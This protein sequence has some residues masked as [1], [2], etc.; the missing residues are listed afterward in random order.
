MLSDACEESGISLRATKMSDGEDETRVHARVRARGRGIARAQRSAADAHRSRARD[1]IVDAEAVT[2]DLE[3]AASWPRPGA[4]PSL[5]PAT[6][7]APPFDQAAEIAKLV[8]STAPVWIAT[9]Q[10]SDRYLRGD[11]EVRFRFVELHRRT[12]LVRLMCPVLQVSPS[13][14][15]GWRS[16]P[17]VSAW[18]RTVSFWRMFGAS[19][20]AIMTAAARVACMPLCARRVDGPAT[21]VRSV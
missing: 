12:W 20:P 6:P 7:V 2:G 18:L 3:R 5:T 14:C 1:S 21:D 10:K 8:S 15:Y 13:G 4:S 19:M 16:R 17:R 11:A 9:C